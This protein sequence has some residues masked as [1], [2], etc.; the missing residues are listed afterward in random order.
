[1]K[2]LIVAVLAFILVMGLMPTPANA[3][4]PYDPGIELC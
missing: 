4:V 3:C 1:M 2:K